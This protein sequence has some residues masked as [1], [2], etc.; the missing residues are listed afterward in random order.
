[1]CFGGGSAPAPPDY[2][3]AA[4]TDAAAAWQSMQ[5]NMFASRPDVYTPFGNMT[6]SGPGWTDYSTG[7]SNNGR[8]AFGPG[9]WSADMTLDPTLQAALDSQQRMQEGRSALSEGLLWRAGSELAADMPTLGG[10]GPTWGGSPMVPNWGGSPVG[11]GGGGSPAPSGGGGSP[12]PSATPTPTSGWHPT[13][14]PESGAPTSDITT[15]LQR[16]DAWGPQSLDA[17]ESELLGQNGYE[18][19]YP[20]A[21]ALQRSSLWGPQSLDSYE[22]GLVGGTSAPSASPSGGSSGLLGMGAVAPNISWAISGAAANPGGGAFGAGAVAPQISSQIADAA[23]AYQTTHPDEWAA[24]QSTLSNAFPGFDF[25]ALF[26]G[27]GGSPSAW[28][29]GGYSPASASDATR[30]RVEQ[31]LYARSASRLDPQWDQRREQMRSELYNQ[32]LRPGMEAY[33]TQMA[34]F[35]RS[36]TDA[37][38]AAMNDS[39]SGGGQEMTRSFDIENAIYQAALA[40]RIQTLNEMNAAV[41]GQQVSMPQMPQTGG[42]TGGTLQPNTLGALSSQYQG[43]LG[44]YNAGQAQ[45]QN[46]WNTAIGLGSLAPLL[47]S[48]ERLKE[49]VERLD[50]EVI[51]GVPAARWTWKDSG[52]PDQGVI[53]QDVQKVRPDLVEVDDCGYLMVNYG[54]L[55]V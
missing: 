8:G 35:D 46:M 51:P 55:N 26:S 22:A 20:V 18:A 31:A 16:M 41:S 39:I 38:S 53:A 48:D 34:N 32:G 52:L 40:R 24:T 13:A 43:Q 5:Y 54:A 30:N 23:H 47:L 14:S 42:G 49:N 6:W 12:A 25:N 33:D 50:Y 7:V 19:K 11:S 21:L 4:N 10:W 44:Q 28:G 2:V 15:A 17:Y 9:A 1:M 36:R 3:G 45:Q 37:Y 27:G 29:G